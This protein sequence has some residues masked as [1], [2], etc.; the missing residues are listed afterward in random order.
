MNY[1]PL[2]INVAIIPADV[3][4]DDSFPPILRY[5]LCLHLNNRQKAKPGVKGRE[6]PKEEQTM[7]KDLKGCGC[8]NDLTLTGGRGGGGR[9]D[10]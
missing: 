3:S 4:P 8:V 10:K 2:P 7:E 1:Q 6:R 9:G 5:V